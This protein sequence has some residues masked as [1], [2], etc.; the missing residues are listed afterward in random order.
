VPQ[1]ALALRVAMLLVE[2]T[3]GQ[4]EALALAE[5]VWDCECLEMVPCAEREPLLQAVPLSP[6]AVAH[7]LGLSVPE[8]VVEWLPEAEEDQEPCGTHR[9]M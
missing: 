2:V 1:L 4:P 6:V 7:R 9:A 3:L 5:S 8:G